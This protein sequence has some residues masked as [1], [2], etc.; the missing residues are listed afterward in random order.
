MLRRQP[1]FDDCLSRW[2][3][4]IL[5]ARTVGGIA[6]SISVHLIP[7]VSKLER[8]L[9]RAQV[10]SLDVFDTAVLRKLDRP[11]SLFQLMLPD[12]SAILG[13]RTAEFPAL[14]IYAEHEIHRRHATSASGPPGEVRFSEIYELLGEILGLEKKATEELSRLEIQAE[15]AVCCQNPFI[16]GIYSR[17]ISRRKPVVFLSDMYLPE[18]VVAEIL[19]NCGYSQYES[20]LVSSSTRKAKASGMLFDEALGKIAV[21]AKHWL[22]I[23]DNPHSDIRMARKRGMTAWRLVSPEMHFAKPDQSFEAWQS[24]RPLPP[25]GLAVKGMLAN[26][27]TRHKSA[28]SKSGAAETFWEDFGY[29]AAGPLYTGFTEWLISRVIKDEPQAIYFLAR[30]GFI[31]RRIFNMLRPPELAAVETHY[32]YASRRAFVL[33]AIRTIDD[34]AMLF[35]TQSFSMNKVGVY[36]ERVGLQAKNHLGAIRSAGFGSASDLVKSSRDI[37]KLRRLIRSLSDAIVDRAREE[38]A[39]VLDYFRQSGLGA[40]RRVAMVDIGW[41]GNQ[42]RAITEMLEAE[43]DLPE[44]KG[45]YLGTMFTANPRLPH[46]AYLFKQGQ[47]HEYERLILR[48]VEIVELLFSAAEGSLVRMARMPSGMVEPVL[49]PVDPDEATRNAIVE[50]VQAGAMQ[51]VADYL[52]LKKHFPE[53]AITPEVAIAQLRRVLSNPTAEEAGHLGDVPHTKD[54]GTST[55]RP[56]SPRLGVFA[57]LNPRRI[58]YWWEGP[59]RVGVEARSSWLYRSLRRLRM[60]TG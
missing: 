19:R 13:E 30:D 49:Q 11:R 45:F 56:I 2:L 20:L 29:A 3:D 41:H 9:D 6:P 52:A 21:A 58:I 35:L 26:R 15:L 14:R 32:L 7:M 27:L 31:I 39:I 53:L 37:E 8:K 57:L 51:F 5:A 22:H 44:I 60:G 54:F 1:Q 33:P 42:Q 18:N 28:A 34:G 12:V 17:C 55:R 16:H 59:W 38:R 46:E 43:G 47:P 23:G 48:C 40:G 25:A 50:K 24:D 4:L 36:L 10:V